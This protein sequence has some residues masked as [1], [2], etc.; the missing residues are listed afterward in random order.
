MNERAIIEILQKA[1]TFWR[2]KAHTWLAE[3][4]EACEAAKQAR[5][6]TIEAYTWAIDKLLKRQAQA[7]PLE[8]ANAVRVTTLRQ[9]VAILHELCAEESL[10]IDFEKR[11]GLEEP[12]VPEHS[13]DEKEDKRYMLKFCNGN[14][15]QGC[16]TKPGDLHNISN[17]ISTPWP[18]QARKFRYL[19]AQ[20]V[21]AI[22]E[23]RGETLTI[24]EVELL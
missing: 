2:A 1:L 5:E 13:T 24:E 16:Y 11:F 10:V 21:R 17:Y 14:Y 23:K 12:P 4:P 19:D 6:R 8:V 9:A 3:N 18:I 20:W 7:D 15:L 22:L